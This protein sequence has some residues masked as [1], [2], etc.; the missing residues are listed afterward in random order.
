[1]RVSG[2]L[3]ALGCVVLCG[4]AAAM[5]QAA[6]VPT[7][8]S[9]PARASMPARASA[10]AVSAAAS[11]AAAQARQEA[12]EAYNKLVS[13]YLHSRWA[14][15]DAAFKDA[16]KHNQALSAPER[17]DV[18]Y[19][20]QSSQDYRPAWWKSCH[21][22]SNT[23]FDAR[24]W[25]RN[26]VANYAPSDALGSEAP[27]AV[28]DGKIMVVV[29]WRPNMV[30]NPKP[31]DGTLAKRLALSEGDLGEAIVWHELGHNYL[32]TALPLKDLA[33]LY[34]E[35]HMLFGHLQEFYAD[36]TSLYHA[37][38]R[39]RLA[40]L[41]SRADALD[42]SSEGEMH[43]RAAYGIGSLILANVLNDPKK[44]PSLHL[45]PKLSE[46]DTELQTILYMYDHIN[47][48]WSLAEDKALRDM[49]QQFIQT[50]GDAVYRSKGVIP[51]PNKLTF[52]LMATDDRDMRTKRDAWVAEQVK[53]AIDSGLA[54]KAATSR[55]TRSGRTFMGGSRIIIPR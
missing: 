12:Q 8:T 33:A 40:V 9:A 20:R 10:P 13:A 39:A 30:D 45:P 35:H 42:E 6:S 32:T 15:L 14:D 17:A 44:W 29:S 19:M 26:F 1:M 54:D 31:L 41:A 53:K 38:P 52:S 21:S 50:K 5:G 3:L 22:S 47:P 4:G 25:G 46:K 11:A 36:M 55:A 49:V 27:V 2:L 48:D 51:L 37:S 16:A 23:S 28:R 7:R 18:N 43:S 34:T 24:I